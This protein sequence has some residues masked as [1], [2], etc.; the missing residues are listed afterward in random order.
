M[1]CYAVQP[2]P[3][4]LIPLIWSR[5]GDVLSPDF[6]RATFNGPEGVEALSF[7]VRNVRDRKAYVS[8]GF[9]WQNDFGAGKVAMS[10][11]TT[12]AGDPFIAK[13]VN[14]AF[15]IG[16]APVP[17]APGRREPRKDLFSGTNL[18]VLKST[19]DKERVAWD[20]IKW[21]TEPKQSA[22][23]TVQTNYLP[24]R[25]SALNDPSLKDYIAKTPRFQVA[26]DL[27]PSGQPAPSVPGWS[28][29]GMALQE[30]ITSAVNQTADPK[31]ALDQAARKADEA[32]A[33]N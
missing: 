32:L 27:I 1:A 13:A 12:I 25:K 22:Y 6:K 9:D 7:D 20:F 26:L 3:D 18:A 10:P 24:I 21:L 28:E 19:P 29:S 30:A 2:R 17:T 5:G 4:S 16:M 11:V 15:E 31:Q 14:N 33:R 8:K 23:W